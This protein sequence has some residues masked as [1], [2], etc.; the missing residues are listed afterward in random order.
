M[1]TTLTI[2][3]QPTMTAIYDAVVEDINGAALAVQARE[4]LD[5]LPSSDY[6]RL[7]T[8]VRHWKARG[9][10]EDLAPGEL[11]ALYYARAVLAIYEGDARRAGERAALAGFWAPSARPVVRAADFGL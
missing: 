1:Q 3:A 6:N 8:T 11:A 5:G 4:V 2:N 10:C 9:D 7:R